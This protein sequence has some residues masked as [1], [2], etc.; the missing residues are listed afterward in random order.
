VCFHSTK[1][2]VDTC[3]PGG[4]QQICNTLGG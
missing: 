2:G 4:I 1:F 3:C